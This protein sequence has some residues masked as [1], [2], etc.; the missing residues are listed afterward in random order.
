MKKT[1]KLSAVL[2]SMMLCCAAL[3]ANTAFAAD[4]DLVDISI[5]PDKESYSQGDEVTFDV[6]VSNKNEYTLDDLSLT[7]ELP[8]NLV[9][10]EN[11]SYDMQIGANETKNYTIHA[12]AAEAATTTASTAA[13][14]TAASTTTAAATTTTAATASAPKTGDSD[15]AN[16]AG[17][18]A[19]GLCAAGLTFA[20]RNKK[21]RKTLA[22]ILCV[23]TTG[24]F[25]PMGSIF[26]ADAAE[27]AKVTASTVFS[28]A[29]EEQEIV[30]SAE[31][32]TGD[33]VIVPDVAPFGDANDDGS[34]NVTEEISSLSGTLE[35]SDKIVKLSYTIQDAH[36]TVVGKGDIPVGAEWSIE[37]F[38]LVV[39]VNFITITA[40]AENGDVYKKQVIIKNS[41]IENMVNL[42][43]DMTDADGD[44]L[45]GYYE[46]WFGTDPD[47]ADSDGDGLPDY[48]EF[49]LYGTDPTKTDT[50]GDGIADPDD[51]NDEDGLSLAKEIELGTDPLCADTD[52]D[53]LSDGDEV[54]VY[55]TD[56]LTADTDGDG[57]KDGAEVKAGLDPKNADTDGNGIND[58]ED[59][60][61]QSVSVPLE[62]TEKALITG[63][64]VTLDVP[65]V[66]DEHVTLRDTAEYDNLSANVVGAVGDPIEIKSDVDFDSAVIT[67][68]YDESKLGDTPVE[69]LAVMWYDEENMMYRIFDKDTVIDTEAHTVSYTTTHFSTYLVVDREI[70]YDCWRENTNYRTSSAEITAESYDIGFTV[71]VSGS[72]SGGRIAKAQTAMNTFIDA[73][74][75]QDNACIVSFNSYSKLCAPY[76]SSKED[77]RASVSAMHA[78]GGTNTN[79]GLKR[80]ISEISENGRS[81]AKKIIIMICDGD[82]YYVQSTIDAANEAGI[83]VY[84]IN[85][86]N[87]NNDLLQ[88]IADQTGGEYYYA[89]TTDEIV[90]KVEK[91]RGDTVNAVDMTDTDGDG[92]YD[93]YESTGMKIQNGQV[94]YSDPENPDS[95]NDGI[96]DY[97]ELNGPPSQAVFEFAHGS[98]SCVLCRAKSDPN[99]DDSDGDTVVDADDLH[100]FVAARHSVVEDTITGRYKKVDSLTTNFQF[101]N[102]YEARTR[103]FQNSVYASCA[104]SRDFSSYAAE[105]YAYLVVSGGAVAL[106]ENASWALSWFLA[107]T[108]MDKEFTDLSM[109]SLITT[110]QGYKRYEKQYIA[111]LEFAED[112][113]KDGASITVASDN[114]FRSYSDNLSG[115]NAINWTATLGTA[116]GAASA[117]I[118]RSGNFYSGPIKYKIYD[119]YDWD[120]DDDRAFI[121]G[122]PNSSLAMMHYEGIARSYFQY[123][124]L[125]D[126]IYKIAGEYSSDQQP[127]E[128]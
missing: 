80:T 65:G 38:G 123:G 122:L 48:E 57:I 120:I 92:L 108:G 47:K 73:L 94:Y 79:E 59:V 121:P 126:T 22:V 4:A 74:Y 66:I 99:K 24:T 106:M 64:S 27:M 42:D 56:P 41:K 26:K 105:T 3:C 93:V 49:Y 101:I 124:V 13:T 31:Y 71:D 50:D 118:T 110:K 127:E 83:A 87:G 63:A 72:M 76:G 62:N 12:K 33:N 125:N 23:S 28:Y 15:S 103:E 20:T 52:D 55:G 34:F 10:T 6:S 1:R 2:S 90:S 86:V 81:N 11:G 77:L 43:V 100:P 85:V 75:H 128:E 37:D 60:T 61:N 115:Y 58:N 14:T 29:G 117:T 116:S 51:D 78:N 95:D 67:F 114:P 54:N 53:D 97:D 35:G 70:W 40:E 44:K 102:D 84:T 8:E 17:I 39:G 98:Y 104:D 5:K 32:T 107:N 96:I 7:A 36:N 21:A 91:V 111:I 82:V 89:A 18:M 25:L 9:I 68:T 69:N 46:E 30:V 109:V 119:Y 19:I 45:I 88:K 112:V 113:L 16:V